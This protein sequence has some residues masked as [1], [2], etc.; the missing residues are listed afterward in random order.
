MFLIL[1]TSQFYAL[2]NTITYSWYI[3]RHRYAQTVIIF[4]AYQKSWITFFLFF[5]VYNSMGGKSIVMNFS[6]IFF[7]SKH[8][9]FNGVKCIVINLVLHR[10]HTFLCVCVCIEN[11]WN[12]AQLRKICIKNRS[13][14]QK[15][16]KEM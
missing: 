16:G 11:E 3:H 4:H 7:F 12:P 2:T 13:E 14:Q 1:Y 6:C 10:Q 9:Y 15:K 8:F 5:L